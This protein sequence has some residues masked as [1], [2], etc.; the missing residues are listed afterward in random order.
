MK[1]FFLGVKRNV[2][3]KILE[4]SCGFH[5][6]NFRRDLASTL[7]SCLSIIP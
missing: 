1:M 6:V 4:H 7:P 2:K 5:A 3:C